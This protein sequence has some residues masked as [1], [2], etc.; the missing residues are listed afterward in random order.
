MQMELAFMQDGGLEDEGGQVEPTS[1]NEV[2]SGSLKE[3]VKDDIPTMLSEGEF[4]FPADVTRYIGLETLMEMRQNA[5]MGLK[6]MEQMGQM[7]NSDE[8]TM[9]DDLP[10]GMADL[11]VIAGGQEENDEPQK[12]QTGGMSTQFRNL[13]SPQAVPIRSGRRNIAMPTTPLINPDGTVGDTTST[14]TAKQVL[15]PEAP[16]VEAPTQAV[17]DP[18]D[19]VQMRG[20][21]PQVN[22]RRGTGFDQYA[23]EDWLGNAQSQENL[24]AKILSF[25]P[26]ALLGNVS[27][28]TGSNIAK[29]ALNTNMFP[30]VKVEMD[31]PFTG[32]TG[33]TVGGKELTAFEKAAL[34]KYLTVEKPQTSIL[35]SISSL[36]G[37]PFATPNEKD[38]DSKE[39]LTELNTILEKSKV[40]LLEDGRIII[41]GQSYSN[42]DTAITTLRRDHYGKSKD[43]PNKD[44]LYLDEDKI[45]AAKI[46]DKATGTPISN[47]F[48]NTGNVNYMN[49]NIQYMGD[50]GGTGSSNM[51][52]FRVE[53]PTT[54]KPIFF[55]RYELE[56]EGINTTGL[57][58]TERIL[59]YL[60]KVNLDTKTFEEDAIPKGSGEPPV[61]LGP[62]SPSTELQDVTPPESPTYGGTITSDESDRFKPPSK[63][64]PFFIDPKTVGDKW[65]SDAVST[66]TVGSRQTSVPFSGINKKTQP[67]DMSSNLT[68]KPFVSTSANVTSSDQNKPPSDFS[69]TP[70]ELTYTSDATKGMAG[71]DVSS[72]APEVDPKNYLYT[73]GAG[74]NTKGIEPKGTDIVAKNKKEKEEKEQQI[75]AGQLTGK[76]YVGGKGFKSGGLAKMK[77]KPTK[78]R[79]GGLASKKK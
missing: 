22:A 18:R 65:L 8:A 33:R 68:A 3:E 64:K 70:S 31:N 42:L 35:Q 15:S 76:G 1:G 79:K 7:G 24:G 9:P 59:N 25:T 11:V 60:A 12:L 74:V 47:V 71:P 63:G 17:Q 48:E 44:F 23:A 19:N 49:R 45:R 58:S 21:D 10:F 72:N 34:V 56:A 13:S 75:K 29:E 32:E 66:P 77:T 69:F 62:F 51:D 2:P 46:T 27:Y 16:K 14:T 5:K 37:L 20:F 40:K 36:I 54:N 67:S 28:A 39:D 61:N 78:K 53:D 41:D 4:V 6:R 55:R 26:M 52:L 50:V 43:N 57:G 73:S 30:E 38:K